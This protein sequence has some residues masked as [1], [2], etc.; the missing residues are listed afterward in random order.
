MKHKAGLRAN[1]RHISV[2]SALGEYGVLDCELT[3][4]LCLP[5]ASP[6]W[7]RQTLASL[8]RVGFV[9]RTALQ[10]W[11]DESGRGGRIP[12][13]CSLTE[14]GAEFVRQHTGTYP[15]RVFRKELTPAT[16][17]HRL[18]IVRV[19]IAFDLAAKHEELTPPSWIH[20]QDYR[21]DVPRDVQ[22]LKRRV[23]YH[24]FRDENAALITCRPDAA[25]TLR[26]PHPS[27]DDSQ[28][29]SLAIHFE[30]DRSSEGTAQYLKKVP[31]YAALFAEQSYTRYWPNLQNPIHRVFWIV[32]SRQ[33]AS[34]LM[35]AFRPF[36]VASRFRFSMFEDCTDRSILTHDVWRDVHDT[37]KRLY[38]RASPLPPPDNGGP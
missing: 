27:G 32:P 4:C 22:P 5:G 13:L 20:E 21:S 18:Q 9:R 15:R 12:L 33:R 38:R 17:W 6:E 8:A 30:I 1:V 25:A 34:N 28:A 14:E 29:T 3:R 36:D 19:R 26:I 16:Y 7:C 37:A 10:I 24:E 11:H 2:L 31:G 23:L 35:T